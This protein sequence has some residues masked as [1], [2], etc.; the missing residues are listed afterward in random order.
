M[1]ENK[2]KTNYHRKWVTRGT[3]FLNIYNVYNPVALDTNHV[4]IIS[5]YITEVKKRLN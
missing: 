1:S 4:E 5:I 2:E 3:K